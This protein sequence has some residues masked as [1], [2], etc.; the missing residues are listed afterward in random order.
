MKKT[1]ADD[2]AERRA[3]DAAEAKREA[4]WDAQQAELAE[5]NPD[6][7]AVNRN[8]M[9]VSGRTADKM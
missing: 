3:H 7:F 8:K 9:C 2:A 1:P 4:E 6:S 5:I